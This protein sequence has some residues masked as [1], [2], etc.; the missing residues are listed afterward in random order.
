[1]SIA[2]FDETNQKGID[3]KKLVQAPLAQS[4]SV[5]VSL[6]TV[7]HEVYICNKENKLKIGRSEML[8]YGATSH[9]FYI[10]CYPCI[11]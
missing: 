8:S 1:M 11:I 7:T 5:Y 2:K 10:L 6:T 4:T 3:E 9:V